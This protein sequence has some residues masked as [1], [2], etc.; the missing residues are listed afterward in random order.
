MLPPRRALTRCGVGTLLGWGG[1][2]RFVVR[3]LPCRSWGCSECRPRLVKR[4]RKTLE[5]AKETIGFVPTQFLTVTMNPATFETRCVCAFHRGEAREVP[6]DCVLMDWRF[7]QEQLRR[8]FQR[9]LKLAK[10][11]FG[12]VTYWRVYEFHKGLRDAKRPGL[13]NW[14]LHIHALVMSQVPDGGVKKAYKPK[15]DVWASLATR[16]GLGRTECYSVP[17]E[18]VAGYVFKY[19]GKQKRACYAWRV[20]MVGCSRSIRHAK[21]P[22]SDLVWRVVWPGNDLEGKVESRK[23]LTD[24]FHTIIKG[25]GGI[26]EYDSGSLGAYFIGDSRYVGKLG[27][28]F[29]VDRCFRRV[30]K[31]YFEEWGSVLDGRSRCRS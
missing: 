15:S 5:L 6:A 21:A 17:A 30:G 19:A 12:A 8:R 13:R 25:M 14:R 18:A 10:A 31:Q 16:C 3:R 23:G 7:L 20:R 22:Q 28:L 26:L 2:G 11:E 27:E 1:G 24:S 29:T 9:M 4:W